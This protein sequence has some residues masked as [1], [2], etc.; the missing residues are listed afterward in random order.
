MRDTSSLTKDGVV[1][2]PQ[3]T[4]APV[5][6]IGD[7][8]IV[9]MKGLRLHLIVLALCI[10]LFL[11]NL[12]VVIVSTS[13]VAITDD[14]GG[15]DRAT[16]IISAY[17][18]GYVGVVI[19]FSKLSDI[20][21]RKLMLFTSVMI[22]VLFSAGCGAAQTLTQL[23]ICRAFQGAG[24][25]GCF[26]LGSIMAFE[27][28]PHAQYAGLTAFMSI[29]Y[30]LS[31]VVGPIMGGA[32]NNSTTWRWVFLL[33]VPASIPAIVIILLCIP[34][35]FPHHGN[36]EL[37]TVPI[38]RRLASANLARVDIFGVASLLLATLAL[39][40]AVE[41]A[42]LSFG[43]NS[44]FVISFLVISAVL[45]TVFLFWERRITF[46]IT[47]ASPE[48]VF[49]WRFATSR[50]WVGM[51][52]NAVFLG[53][54]WSGI[55][56]QL[57]QRFQVINEASSIGAG[58]R[59]LPFTASAPVGSVVTAALAKKGV[60]PIYLVMFASILQVIGFALLGTLRVQDG[61]A[62]SSA[63]YGYQAMAG[64]GS[65]TNISLLTLMTPFSVEEKDKAV[66][67]G[68]I[69]QFR[70]M[71]GAIGL[72]ILNTAM[73]GYLKSKLAGT[74]PKTELGALLNSAQALVGLSP[75]H[76]VAART[77][78]VHGYNL[79]MQILAG[80]AGIQLLGSVLMWQ[81]KQIKV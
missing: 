14:L 67:I 74:L 19:I 62:I 49:P 20:F 31:L 38:T 21:G 25:A 64:F 47:G 36:P 43:W 65:G 76:Q 68:A 33:N 44:P 77:A 56:F 32:I 81:K 40:A 28:V 22:F 4:P 55:V 59:L 48:P 27:L 23:I 39:V 41:E 26:G 53:A 71:G 78:L 52:I 30:S 5:S 69:T 17:L 1:E 37:S 57:P 46:N 11:T 79:Q 12:E 54:P 3:Q 63:Q 35:R 70:V 29:V 7:S 2:S 13:L 6:I 60:S 34:K 42:G 75:S 66:A 8:G 16:W 10:A 72:S 73:H 50:V 15:F 9:Y 61:F 80:L 58:I 18:L 45:W 24:G 51:L